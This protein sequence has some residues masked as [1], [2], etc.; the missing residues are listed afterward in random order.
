MRYVISF[1][2]I[3]NLSYFNFPK[4]YP[5]HTDHPG[6][7]LQILGALVIVLKWGWSHLHASV[8]GLEAH[9]LLNSESYIRAINH[10]LVLLIGVMMFFAGRRCVRHTQSWLPMAVMQLVP[11]FYLE[12]M[13]AMYNVSPE[14]LLIAIIYGLML[15]LMP[16]VFP[17]KQMTHEDERK[18]A[19][20]L[21]VL[22]GLGMATKVTFFP[23]LLCV[24]F[25]S[26][27]KDRLITAGLTLVSFIVFTAPIIHRYKF[28][29]KWN[30]TV[31][32]HSGK[33]GEGSAG[34]PALQ[35]MTN[36]TAI[37]WSLA[38][39]LFVFLALFVAVYAHLRFGH[40][41]D[42]S[43]KRRVQRC[44]GLGAL[45]LAVQLLI[46]IKHP[47]DRYLLPSMIFSGL[48]FAVAIHYYASQYLRF[49][50]KGWFHK[51]VLASVLVAVVS[52]GIAT[53]SHL[54]GL[55]EIRQASKS[56]IQKTKADGCVPMGA[57]LTVYRNFAYWFADNWNAKRLGPALQALK[58]EALFYEPS[59]DTFH[60]FEGQISRQD[61]QH[62]LDQG[63]CIYFQ[64]TREDFFD[65]KLLLEAIPAEGVSASLPLY[66][67]KGFEQGESLS[68]TS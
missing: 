33:Y 43:C 23:L 32:K 11:F 38:P 12:T 52:S 19:L 66:Q 67:L 50:F 31:L 53:K 1:R 57:Y 39:A 61:V 27:W 9:V 2:L 10:C 36:N 62:V 35:E 30:I 22:F 8:Q 40:P 42:S 60:N 24:F 18:L 7:T 65:K 54:Q 29:L 16:V 25:L 14:P 58:P 55:A 46:T 15:L 56:I 45:M 20:S 28:M 51:G 44:I 59:N 37:L 47:G 26:R 63:T 68:E 3:L 34:L 41:A 4:P 17:L 13:V 21:G 5:R 48:L 64:T 49:E 6:T